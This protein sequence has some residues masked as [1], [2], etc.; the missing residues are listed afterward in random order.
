MYSLRSPFFAVV[1]QLLRGHQAQKFGA[2]LIDAA[3]IGLAFLMQDGGDLRARL[4]MRLGL[5]LDLDINHF[6][7]QA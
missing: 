6:L 7:Q 3:F 2:D 1:R 5:L 4:E